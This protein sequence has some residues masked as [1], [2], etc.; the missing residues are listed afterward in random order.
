[1]EK[2]G[3]VGGRIVY[4]EL[5]RPLVFGLIIK[6]IDQTSTPMSVSLAPSQPEGSGTFS[7]A[8]W[9]IRSGR[10]ARLAAAA[11]GLSQMGVGCAVLTETKLTDDRYPKFVQGYHAIASRAASPQQGGVA[12][13]WRESEALG[14]LVEGVNV[15]SPNILTFQLVTGG[16][17]FYVMGAYIPPADT[18]G[19][20]DLRSAWDK[21]PANCHPLLLGYLNFNFG[22]PCSKREEIIVDLLDEIGLADM[23]RKFLQRWRNGRQGGRRWTWRQRRGGQWHQSQPDYCMARERDGKL[24][25]N[26]AVR[27]PWIHDSDHRA[28]VASIRRGW[29]GQLKAYR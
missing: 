17:R 28:V 15:V 12:L 5:I 25:R 10:G 3:N 4:V 14:F 20:V 6:L 26:V 23:S 22:S 2:L 13:L 27:Q 9:N 11:K 7:V 19:V 18:T 8:T 24:F 16:V 21:C 1:M 29:P